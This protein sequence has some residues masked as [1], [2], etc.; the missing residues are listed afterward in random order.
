MIDVALFPIPNSVNFPGVPVTLH[1]FEPRY[2]QMVRY[3]LDNDVMMGVCYTGKVIY[4]NI[5]EQTREEALSSNQSTYKPCEVFSAGKVEL[6]DELDDGR[7][8][9]VVDCEV[10][11]KL[12]QERQTLP[13]SIWQCE[14]YEDEPVDVEALVRLN[15]T[16]DKILQRLLTIGHG[17][18][19]FHKM[20]KSDHWQNLSA[21]EFSFMVNGLFGIPA[22]LKQ[23]LLEMTDTQQRLDF[24]LDMLNS[25]QSS[26]DG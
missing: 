1:V 15:Q 2:R 11:L 6:L 26:F 18:D 9:I 19:E 25:I 16:Q 22:E 20:L 13:F 3:C 10:R 12:K 5:R 4:V 17:N 8:A 24:I 23:D 14:V 7:M 21:V